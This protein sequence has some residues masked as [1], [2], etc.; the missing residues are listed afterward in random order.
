M[1]LA[2]LI[3]FISTLISVTVAESDLP[4]KV[5]CSNKCWEDGDLCKSGCKGVAEFRCKMDCQN[6]VKKCQNSCQF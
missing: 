6:T 2:I 4:L 1:K 5:Q 3:A